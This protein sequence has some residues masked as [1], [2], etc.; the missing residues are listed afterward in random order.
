[1]AWR[2]GQAYGH[3]LRDR[4]LAADGSIH[5]VAERFAVSDSY[6]A[7]ARSRRRRLGQVC[8]GAQCNHVP[9]RLAGLAVARTHQRLGLGQG[10]F[11]D[12]GMRVAQAADA[13]GIRGLLVHAISEEAR[14][15]YLGL[16]LSPSPLD[17][18]MLMVTLSDLRA[19]MEGP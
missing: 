6:V 16:G 19:T 12:A 15:F 1:M 4:V 14:N 13:I 9:P 2:P 3:D 18:L 11:R 10:L 7:R 8:A 17:P 5:E